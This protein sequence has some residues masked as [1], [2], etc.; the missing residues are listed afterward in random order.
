LIITNYS[1]RVLPWY[2]PYPVFWVW[3]RKAKV[4]KGQSGERPKW[5]KAKVEK[6]QSGEWPKN[7][8]SNKNKKAKYFYHGIDSFLVFGLMTL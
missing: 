7:N 5:R 2:D 1:L 8:W 3:Q 4:E 6:G